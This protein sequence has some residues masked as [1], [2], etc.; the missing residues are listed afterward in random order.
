MSNTRFQKTPF[1]FVQYLALKVF[2]ALFGLLPYRLAVKIG[3]LTTGSVRF[4]MPKRFGRSV[5]DI[6]K[7]F[8]EKSPEECRKIALES[9]RNMGAIFAEF[10]KLTTFKNPDE[11]KKYS[12]IIGAEK[13][14]NAQDKTGGIIHIGH[15]TNWEAFG[16]AGAVYGVD[17][18]VLA[19]R[20]DNPYID[21]ETNRLR[22][23]F[24]GRTFYSNHEDKPF[25]ACMR[26]LKKKKMLGILFDQN[27]VS[28]EVWIPFMGR[29]AA[30][31]PITA[32]LSI[33]MQVPVFPVRVWREKDGA[34]VSE[35]MDP[36][37]PPTD[38]SM[39]N[40]RQFTKQLVGYYETWLREN[41]A[42]WLWAHNRWKRE[43]EGNAYLEKHPEERV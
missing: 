39:D 10:I 30:F 18:A 42:S 11:F 24:T 43:A 3:R 23:I 22:N 33:K 25:F 14:L 12:R 7:A 4:I 1:Y 9:W 28:G 16:L 8:P 35:V 40:V 38:F 34:I 21:E 26:W 41:P 13:M 19:Q 17:K 32:L 15:F 29:T 5:T 20:V 6:Q 37:Y 2:C 27:T 31:S 36:L